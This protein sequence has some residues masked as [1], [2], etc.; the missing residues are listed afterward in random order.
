MIF[1]QTKLTIC[2]TEEKIV[3]I[4]KRLESPESTIL[5]QTYH[6][7]SAIDDLIAFMPKSKELTDV[8]S[9]P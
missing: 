7:Q 6:D 4:K 2:R 9:L 1:V 3:Q 8:S 5:H